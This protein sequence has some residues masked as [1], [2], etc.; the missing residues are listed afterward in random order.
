[1]SQHRILLVYGTSYGQ[2]QK[3]AERMRDLLAEHSCDVTLVRGDRLEPNLSLSGYDGVLVGAS[4]VLSKHQRYIKRFAR[5]HA[6]QL[7]A[8]PSAFFSVS[9]SAGSTLEHDRVE[10]Q[11]I[12][13]AF[14][15]DTGWKP[16][17]T[18]TIAGAIV[19]TKYNF[20][21]RWFMKR[22]S[23]REGGSTDTSRDHEYTDWTQVGRFTDEFL[24]ALSTTRPDLAAV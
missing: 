1:M 15:A 9:G 19:Y 3:I 11:G 22:I 12:V 8:L 7:N 5:E 18:A 17:L 10:L 21:L 2:T 24:A 13:D 16:K 6:S 14:L 4:I 23:A 20:V